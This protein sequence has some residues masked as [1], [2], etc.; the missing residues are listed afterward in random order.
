MTVPLG[1]S[2]AFADPATLSAK[3]LESET[4]NRIYFNNEEIKTLHMMLLIL[5]ILQ[6][7]II[8]QVITH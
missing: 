6:T 4:E 7:L 8:N 5:H 1:Q 2:L 3:D